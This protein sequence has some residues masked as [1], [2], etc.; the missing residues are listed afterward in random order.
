LEAKSIREKVL[1]K[2]HPDYAASLNNLAILYNVKGDYDKAEPLYLEAKSIREKVLGKEHPDYATY[3]YN[4][5]SLYGDKGEHIKSVSYFLSSN[6]ATKFLLQLAAIFNSDR[7]LLQYRTLF[8]HRFDAFLHFTQLYST[9]S[10]RAAA[11]DN[12]LF[13]NNSLLFS[14]I[15]REKS[16]AKADSATRAIHAERKS[17]HSQLSKLY[18]QPI[19]ERDS[20]RTAQLEESANNYEKE[21]AR[22][23][24][25]FVETRREVHWQD[26]QAALKPTEAAVEFVRY[27]V[28][29]PEENDSFMYAALILRPMMH[30]PFFVPLF[31]ERELA[32]RLNASIYNEITLENLYQKKDEATQKSLYELVWLP[33]GDLL[34]GVKTVYFAPTGLL[35]RINFSTIAL[36]DET[37][38]LSDRFKIVQVGSTRRLTE[39]PDTEI[40]PGKANPSK[41]DYALFLGGIKYETDTTSTDTLSTEIQNMY[42]SRS[43]FSDF[44]HSDSTDRRGFSFNYLPG[45][46]LEVDSIAQFFEKKKLRTVVLK[47]QS[48]SE[49]N[50]MKIGNSGLSPR[51]LHIATHGFFFPD[52][53]KEGKEQRYFSGVD[54]YFKTSDNPMLRSGLLLAGC[55][56]AWITGK[57]AQKNQPD[58]ILTAYEV[59]QL[60]LKNTELV[61]L[62]A[63][64]TGRGDISGNE[65]V[66]GL[67]RAFK[68]AG[69]RYLLMS[70]WKVPDEATREL[71]TIFY[72][73]FLVKKME[74]P[75]AFRQAQTAMREKYPNPYYWGAWVLLE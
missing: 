40:K 47:E 13:L 71:M 62:S 9:D 18:A 58:G 41:N 56:H 42:A 37:K 59:S 57:P 35:H 70:L 44:S 14:A 48:A 21:L 73:N 74:I 66:Y 12:A 15:A 54:P 31:E 25:A 45:T 22:R 68:I 43:E 36:T 53:K 7:E 16:I 61:V 30:A 19:A 33:I 1:G 63:C 39:K 24:P 49:L 29:F 5:A 52:P 28:A 27:W 46:A 32:K 8:E 38:L 75:E 60:D 20:A 51:I 55:K 6:S 2:E 50:L 3:L 11:Y 23:S 72:Q 67:Q 17:C 10:L 69:A 64:E 4:L 65:G 26:V 34:S